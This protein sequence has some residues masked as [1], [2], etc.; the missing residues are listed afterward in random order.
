[1]AFCG[2]VESYIVEHSWNLKIFI[3]MEI[4]VTKSRGKSFPIKNFAH[5]IANFAKVKSESVSLSTFR[6]SIRIDGIGSTSFVD[7]D[8]IFNLIKYS[9]KHMWII[10]C[11][12]IR[13]FN[14]F[15]CKI[16]MKNN[17]MD[18]N[19]YNNCAKIANFH[20]N[21]FCIFTYSEKILSWFHDGN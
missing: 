12:I 1:M 19:N 4:G 10:E 20:V 17:G 14:N 9:F 15:L 13:I 8:W 16:S 2:Y 18:Y 6:I 7:F 5:F 21:R 11:K 3:R